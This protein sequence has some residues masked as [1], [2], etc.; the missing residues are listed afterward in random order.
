MSS[1]MQA[2]QQ[3][4]SVDNIPTSIDA[5]C[6]SETRIQDSNS[7]IQLIA[8]NTLTRYFMRITRT[9]AVRDAGQ[10]RVKS[11]VTEG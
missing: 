7:A 4:F 1:H 6:V 9:K 8:S 11:K 2:F 5:C 10:C 3:V